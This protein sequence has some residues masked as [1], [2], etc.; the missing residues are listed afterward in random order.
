MQQANASFYWLE[1]LTKTPS[2]LGC[3]GLL[4]SFGTAF[5]F[6]LLLVLTAVTTY[7]P[8]KLVS[9]DPRQERIS[10]IM[11]VFFFYI[12]W[13]LPAGLLLY[14]VTTNI[15]GLVQQYVQMKLVKEEGE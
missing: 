11:N 2:E 6:F 13:I 3:S 9:S 7:L 14:W 5:P 8:T 15:L 10:L 1:S 4:S 12:A